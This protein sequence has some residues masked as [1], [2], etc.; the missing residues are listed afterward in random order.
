MPSCRKIRYIGCLSSIV[1]A[2]DPPEKDID[3]LISIS[4]PEPQRSSFEEKVIRQLGE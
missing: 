4:G 3:L 1:P 2:T